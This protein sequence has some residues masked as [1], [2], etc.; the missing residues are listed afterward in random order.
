MTPKI[1]KYKGK[2]GVQ[3]HGKVTVPTVYKSPAE[4]AD[5]WAMYERAAGTNP[6]LIERECKKMLEEF[7]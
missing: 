1:V 2:F 3:E 4:A 6:K 7:K 5:E